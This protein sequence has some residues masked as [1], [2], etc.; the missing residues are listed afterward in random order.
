MLPFYYYYFFKQQ[1]HYW[2]PLEMQRLFATTIVVVLGNLWKFTSM[3]RY[4]NFDTDTSVDFHHEME[5]LDWKK[6]K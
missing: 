4:W 2:K 1:I 6:A 5:M 3:K